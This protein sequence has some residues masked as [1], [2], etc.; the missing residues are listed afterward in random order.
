MANGEIN[1]FGCHLFVKAA[2]NA[3]RACKL[4]K[5]CLTAIDQYKV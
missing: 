1:F 2:I 4:H 3:P 5:N